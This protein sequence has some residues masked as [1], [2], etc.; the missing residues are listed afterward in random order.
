MA[1]CIIPLSS[2]LIGCLDFV[3]EHDSSPYRRLLKQPEQVA[4]IGGQKRKIAVKNV[5]GCGSEYLGR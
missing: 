3:K 2:L 4:A 5:V 1:Y